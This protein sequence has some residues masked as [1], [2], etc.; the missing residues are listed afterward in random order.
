MLVETVP[1]H[2][3]ATAPDALTQPIEEIDTTLQV[4]FV[5]DE[6]DAMFERL[7]KEAP[8]HWQANSQYGPFWNVTRYKDIV[9]I[10][11]DH[12]TF[13]NAAANG[14]VQIQD[15]PPHLM[16]KSFIRAD[17]PL[18]TVQRR[19]VSPV[20]AP[21]NLVRMEEQVR[22][23]ANDILDSLP[24]GEDF[25]W[26]DR[27]AVELTGRVLAELMDTP[28][29]ERRKLAYWSDVVN[30][31]LNAAGEMDTEE[32]RYEKIRECAAYFAVHFKERQTRPPGN[33]LISMLAHSLVTAE[34]DEQTFVGMV[35]T[36]M[37]GGN[38]T[39]RNSI[40]GGLLALNQFP[41]QYVKLRA[42]PQLVNSM[43]PE[44]LRWVTPV[45]HMR[46]NVTQDTEFRGQ[47]MKKGDKV[48]IWYLSANRDAEMIESPYEFIVDRP[49]PRKH[50]SFGMGI[51]RCLGNRLAELQ[52]RVLWE[53]ILKR[54]WIIDV[55][56][57][58]KRKFNNA[59]RGFSS[60]SVRIRNA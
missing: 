47:K 41:E 17:P 35:V 42:N 51:H 13:S 10:E 19:V 21:S 2:L 18:H 12:K 40:V 44:I 14:G 16:R 7:R 37:V 49:D 50:L 28:R 36:L 8:V 4:R 33:D 45:P 56:G 43:V 25:D 23:E 34:M 11:V 15:M 32:K 52:L 38:D 46:R 55:T 29:H 9:D 48:I 26:V 27:V 22:R 1:P 24:I 53:E 59:L 3:M 31:D 54:N 39:T 30:V 58:A 6:Q 57:P 60:M 5:H 20:V